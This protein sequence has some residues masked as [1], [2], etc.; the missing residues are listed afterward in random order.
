MA[1]LSSQSDLRQEA[2]LVVV[3]RTHI[4]RYTYVIHICVSCTYKVKGPPHLVLLL[5]SCLCYVPCH[6]LALHHHHIWMES[7]GHKLN[8]SEHPIHLPIAIDI[9]PHLQHAYS[10]Y[11]ID[12]YLYAEGS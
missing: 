1:L 7:L 11:T 4:Y 5:P 9:D 8:S 6:F 12:A 2:F 10:A 3:I